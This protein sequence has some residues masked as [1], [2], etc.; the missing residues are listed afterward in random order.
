[1][2]LRNKTNF[3][4]I[5]CAA[6]RPNMDIGVEEITRWHVDDNGWSDIGYH[7]VIRRNGVVEEGRNL[8][9]MGA[10][11]AG[12]NH[13]SLGVCMVGGMSDDLLAENNFTDKQWTALKDLMVQL[14]VDYPDTNII[15]HNE[16]SAKEC[17]SFD[18][19]QWK[20]DNM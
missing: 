12:Y 14:Q 17:P 16:I 8:K 3:I 10:H 9:Y 2:N 15:G 5:H 20:K 19:Q 18:V 13:K 7:K 11:A 4:V 6:T 1:M